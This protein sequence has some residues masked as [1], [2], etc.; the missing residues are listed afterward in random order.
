MLSV[1]VLIIAF[2]LFFSIMAFSHSEKVGVCHSPPGEP[3]NRQQISISVNAV[4]AHLNHGDSII[5]DVESCNGLDD[6]CDGLLGPEEPWIVSET[7]EACDDGLDND[8]DGLVDSLDEDCVVTHPVCQQTYSE[9]TEYDRNITYRSS[10]YKCDNPMATNW[11]RFMGAAGDQ[12]PTSPV[13]PYSCRTAAPGWLAGSHPAVSDG[14]VARRVCFSWQGSS[15]R[16]YTNVNV[17]NCSDYMLYQLHS[18]PTC[19]LRYCGKTTE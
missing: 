1:R 4:N 17:V 14:I 16:W 13:P 12:M 6:D 8:C 2:C 3:T 15:C 11:Y 5:A 10:N 7:E 19:Y 18:T 9:L